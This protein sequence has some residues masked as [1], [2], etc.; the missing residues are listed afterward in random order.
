[1]KLLNYRTADGSGPGRIITHRS[2]FVEDIKEIKQEKYT[3]EA[4]I[5]TKAGEEI[6]TIDSKTTL[7]N[8]LK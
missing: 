7:K 1:M 6:Q 2:M 4:V 3:R 8:R 5:V